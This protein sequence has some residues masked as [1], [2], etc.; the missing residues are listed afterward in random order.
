MALFGLFGSTQDMSTGAYAG[1]ESASDKAARKDTE[2]RAKRAAHHRKA[3]TKVDRQV[4][5]EVDANVRAERTGRRGRGW[6]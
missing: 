4:S 3:A 6:W 5:A 2:A 1:R